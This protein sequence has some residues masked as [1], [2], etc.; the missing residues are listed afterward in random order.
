[1]LDLEG[2]VL[3]LNQQA[4]EILELPREHVVGANFCDLLGLSRETCQVAIRQVRDGQRSSMEV[5]IPSVEGVRTLET[6]MVKIDYGGREAI[7][8]L[9]H[10]ISER[11]ALERM[12]EDLTHMIVHDL[13]NPLGSIMGSLQLIHTAFVERDETLPVTKL[14]R[15]AMRSGQKLYLLIDSLLD[16]GR[17]EAGEAE[18]IKTSVHPGLLVQEAVDQIQPL[19]LAKRQTI[20]VQV[21]PDL[22]AVSVDRDLILRVLT[23]LLDNAVKFTLKEGHITLSVERMR[24]EML[25]IVSDTGIGIPPEFRQ[26]IF[27][28]FLRLENADGVKGTGLGLAFCKLALEAHGGRIW[29]ESE[30]GEGSH[31]KF[32]L[33]LGAE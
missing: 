31:F 6:H 5:R 24:Y 10:E 18:L 27:D 2:E 28:R 32:T 15:I 12:R 14:L 4:V 21:A 1:V 33:P 30:V 22:P 29:V 9:G 8:W 26:R 17:L 11:V 23:N 20:E 16:L 25:F 7:Q 3:N 13:R 19:A